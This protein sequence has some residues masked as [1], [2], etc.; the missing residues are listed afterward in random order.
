MTS[1]STLLADTSPRPVEPSAPRL[2]VWTMG[3]FL[4]GSAQA[5]KQV[6]QTPASLGLGLLFVLSAGLAREYDGED[7]LHEPWHVLLPL[8]ASLA[9]SLILYLLLF[10]VSWGSIARQHGFVR[11][12]LRFLALYWMTA[13]L[14]WLYAI[15][16]EHFL[17][18]GDAMGFNL[19]MLAIVSLWRVALMI[20]IV[21]VVFGLR[22]VAA[23]FVVMCFADAVMLLL[24]RFV[25]LPLLSMMGG[26]RLSEGERLLTETSFF[27]VL[28]GFLSMWLWLPATLIVLACG[29]RSRPVSIDL[30]LSRGSISR[31]AWL[32]AGATV[33]FGVLLLPLTQPAQQRRYEA[34]RALRAG[35]IE[36]ALKYM[37]S[38][39]QSDFPPHWD[40]PPRLSY[41]DPA[42]DIIDVMETMQKQD[43]AP[44]V[45]TI[46]REKFT[47]YVGS[48]H[49]FD[50]PPHE[51]GKLAQFL[52]VL[53]GLPEENA[54]EILVELESE[55]RALLERADDPQRGVLLSEELRA[56]AERA[57]AKAE[58]LFNERSVV[59]SDE[60]PDDQNNSSIT[61]P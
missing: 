9:T 43:V 29:F 61:S 12:Y 44:W 60:P 1:A 40:P 35:E 53:E 31:S 17:D 27:A 16:V 14:A 21:C 10:I 30:S 2:S 8:G 3:R 15:P 28:L 47:S 25:E 49:R 42:P 55:F 20:R 4:I 52:D 50:L 6:A 19:S 54:N 58:Q 5:I 48:G 38:F 36:Y 34:E 41:G 22:P 39:E 45:E 46:Y 57:H 24:L 33:L 11:T 59:H 26:I 51:P 56:R 18:S 37:S 7:L 13:P 23:F 32:A